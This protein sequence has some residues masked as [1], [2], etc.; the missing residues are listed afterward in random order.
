MQVPSSTLVLYCL[1]QVGKGVLRVMRV[2]PDG[3]AD[4]VPVDAT[5]NMLIAIGWKTGIHPTTQP[6]V[7]HC[8]SGGV[9]PC[10]WRMM[11]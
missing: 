5:S 4:I 8:T 7:Y 10:T 2:D 3:I 9:N 11:C 1:L 6:A